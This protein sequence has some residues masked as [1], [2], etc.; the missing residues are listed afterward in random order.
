MAFSG[1]ICSKLTEPVGSADGTLNNCQESV[2][3][4]VLQTTYRQSG[5]VTGMGSRENWGEKPPVVPD[6]YH[7]LPRQRRIN[8]PF[9]IDRFVKFVR[10]QFKGIISQETYRQP[11]YR[12]NFMSAD[13]VTAQKDKKKT[14]LS[15]IP[16]TRREQGVDRVVTGDKETSEVDEELASDVKEDEEEVDAD[17]TQDRI[18]LGDV[19]LALQ[20]VKDGVLGE[21]R[22]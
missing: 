6:R 7:G 19:G 8:N 17:K 21:L 18:H 16:S 20:V 5:S 9:T 13:P 14:H 12:K 15:V 10:R 22:S 1:S 2:D 11:L 3:N 4:P